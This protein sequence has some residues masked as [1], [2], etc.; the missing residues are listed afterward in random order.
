MK[1]TADWLREYC[2]SGLSVE[3]LAHRLSM[4]GCLIEETAPVGDDALMVAEV[5]ANRPDLLGV[6]GIAREVAALTGAPL[7]LPAADVEESAEK[8]TAATSVEVQAPDLCPRYTARLIRGVK[9]GPSPEWL[10]RRLE[11]VGVRP[12]N[13]VVDVTNFVMLECGQPLHAFDF[14]K[15]HGGRIVVRR[16]VEGEVLIS[17]DETKCK[18]DPSMPIIADADRPVAIAGVMGGLDT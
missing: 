18:L 8:I 5:T 16:G 15:L 1:I 10:A 14:D 3:D 6:I 12:I 2:D 9:V 17:I 4:S 7:R 13:N 11:A